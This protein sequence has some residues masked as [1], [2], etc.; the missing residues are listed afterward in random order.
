MSRFQSTSS[1]SQ[2]GNNNTVIFRPF[3]ILHAHHAAVSS[4]ILNLM[5]IN[6]PWSSQMSST[7]HWRGKTLGR[8]SLGSGLPQGLAKS[9]TM[10]TSSSNKRLKTWCSVPKSI[11]IEFTATSSKDK[12]QAKCPQKDASLS[13][14]RH[15]CTSNL[16]CCTQQLKVKGESV[17]TMPVSPWLTLDTYPLTIWTQQR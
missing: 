10:A 9:E 14:I 12:M 15:I 8:P 7:H 16:P 11:R 17:C 2:Q 4:S 1:F 5:F 3:P 13:V 6:M